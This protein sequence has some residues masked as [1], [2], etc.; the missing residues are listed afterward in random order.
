MYP[1]LQRFF[2]HKMFKLVTF[3]LQLQKEPTF[4]SNL[5]TKEMKKIFAL[6][7]FAAA[8][9]TASAQVYVGGSLGLWRDWDK[10]ETQLEIA[11]EVGYKL[12]DKWEIGTGVG[13]GYKY[14][15][16]VKIHAFTLAP[17]ARWTYAKFDRV[18]LFLQPSAEW[19]MAKIQDF[20]DAQNFWA[21]GVKPGLAVE[22]TDKLNFVAHVGFLGYRDSEDGFQYWSNRGIGFKLDGNALQ[23]GLSYNF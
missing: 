11:P 20:G 19:G 8:T 12:S 21:V 15:D 1:F 17:Y 2:L 23:F 9:M 6:V 18:S 7:A 4:L 13:Y 14:N 22:L 10:N 3:V 16:G 5:K